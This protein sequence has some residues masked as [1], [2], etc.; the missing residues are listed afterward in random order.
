MAI[1]QPDIQ[2]LQTQYLR[3]LCRSEVQTLVTLRNGKRLAGEL[4]A[5]DIHTI[6]FTPKQGRHKGRQY[7]I[8][9]HAIDSIAKLPAA[10]QKDREP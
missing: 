7:L 4:H 2:P 8:F 5:F 1:E 6:L 10:Q 3:S 9:K